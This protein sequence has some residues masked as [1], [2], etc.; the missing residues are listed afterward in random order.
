MGTFAEDVIVER[1]GDGLYRAVLDHSW[2]LV[3]GPQGGVL[4]ALGLRAAEVE[5]AERA[6]SLRSCTAVFAGRVSAGELRIAVE[7]VRRGRTAT[8]VAVGVHNVDAQ[9]GTRLLAVYGSSRPGPRFVDVVPPLVPPPD[10]CRSFRDPLPEGVEPFEIWP[11]WTRVEGRPA[12]GHAPWEEFTPTTSDVAGWYRFDTPPRLDDGSL[13]PLAVVTLAD[14]MPGCVGERVGRQ[15][16]PWFAPSADLT[17]HLFEPL[18]T[19][20]L[21]AHDRA[22]WADDGWASAETTLWDERGGLIGYATQVM[23]FTYR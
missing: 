18:R 7:V 12:L 13:D 8:Q 9:S 17:V 22:R 14:R 23:F 5:L 16:D 19:E 10:Q 2:D 4:T 3:G 21:L 6:G 15:E 20:W 1:L 11:F